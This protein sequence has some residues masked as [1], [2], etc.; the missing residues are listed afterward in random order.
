MLNQ[1]RWL[2][3]LLYNIPL[4][5]LKNSLV[6][7]N[8]AWNNSDFILLYL[9]AITSLIH[10]RKSVSLA[11]IHAHIMILPPP[12]FT[13]EVVCFGS[14]AVP[15]LLYT[16]FFHPLWYSVILS[17]GC[18]SRTVKAFLDVVWETRLWLSCFWG[19]QWFPSCVELCRTLSVDVFLICST[20]AKGF[21]FTWEGLLQS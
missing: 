7:D 6:A 15:F 11:T 9:S 21:F 16:L 4:H 5:C 10:T 12:C 18:C 17:I 13:D 19:D 3:W 8:I 2:P 1:V 20:V 14:W